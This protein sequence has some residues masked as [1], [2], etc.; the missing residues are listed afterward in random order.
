MECLVKKASIH[1]PSLLKK[2]VTPHVF[3]HTTA[4]HLLEA[5]VDI[6]TIAIWLGH[7]SIE[8]THKYMTAD[9]RLKEKALAKISE[10]V[11][12][13]FRYKPNADILSFLDTL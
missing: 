1:C 10:P 6:S 4:M 3:R 9:L 13:K 8:T 2:K 12:A 7:E 5:G 11:G